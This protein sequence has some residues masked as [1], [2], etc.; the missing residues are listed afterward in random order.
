MEEGHEFLS[1]LGSGKASWRRQHLSRC[2]RTGRRQTPGSRGRCVGR[3]FLATL[4]GIEPSQ[5]SRACSHSRVGDCAFPVGF[6]CALPAGGKAPSA[7]GKA[8]CCGGLAREPA[9]LRGCGSL[10]SLGA[11]ASSCCGRERKPGPARPCWLSTEGLSC[12]ISQPGG[13]R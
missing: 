12:D 13:P 6:H 8:T 11:R 5:T 9:S 7:A 1:L 10:R 2:E 3:R 4:Y